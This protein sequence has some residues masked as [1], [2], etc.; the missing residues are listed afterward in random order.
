MAQ[1]GYT[2]VVIDADLR[3][4]TQHKIFGVGNDRGL[5]TLLIHPEMPWHAAA[6]RTDTDGLLLIP[7]GPIPP[8]PADLL[9]LGRFTQLLA[10]LGEAVDIV[11]ID[12]SPVLAVSDPLIVGTAADAVAVVCQAGRTRRDALQRAVALLRQGGIR[13]V[14]VV[15][16]GQQARAGEGY[17]YGYYG[18]EDTDAEERDQGWT[19]PLPDL[20]APR[21]R[22][23]A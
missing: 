20:T 14:G 9:G 11:L 22:I 1:G 18:Q 17:Y 23:G 13:L 6:T 12:T 4:P 10:E 2:V 15:L 7:S 5:T 3:R 16:N 21:R 8:N 19:A